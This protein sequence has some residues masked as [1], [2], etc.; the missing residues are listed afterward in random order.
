MYVKKMSERHIFDKLRD[1]HKTFHS[2]IN[3]KIVIKLF[4]CVGRFL[5]NFFAVVIHIKTPSFS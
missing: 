3:N 4:D 1:A 5:G 2:G